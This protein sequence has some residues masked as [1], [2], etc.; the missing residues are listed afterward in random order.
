MV[1]LIKFRDTDGDPW[2]WSF[3]SADRILG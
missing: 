3:S 1:N 2:T